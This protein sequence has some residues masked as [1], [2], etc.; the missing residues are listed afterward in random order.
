[1]FQLPGGDLLR[2]LTTNQTTQPRRH[3]VEQCRR[4]PER[5]PPARNYSNWPSIFWQPF[6]VA[7]LLPTT[8]F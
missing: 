8:V 1:M 7:T 5:P 4:K 2:Q 3:N 6:L